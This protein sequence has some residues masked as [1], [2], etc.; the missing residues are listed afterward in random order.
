M[1]DMDPAPEH[2][3]PPPPSQVVGSHAS[4]APPG[5]DLFRI[6]AGG[7]GLTL[8]ADHHGR[9]R[10]VGLGLGGATAEAELDLHWFPEAH[11]VWG[12]ADPLR[13]PALRITH[14]DGTLTTRLRL[15]EVTELAEPEGI[16]HVLT[17][18][19]ELF[20]LTVELHARTHP[21]SGVLEQW[22]EVVHAEDAPVRLC[23]YDSIAPLLLVEADA[24]VVQ[25]GGSGWADEWRWTAQRIHP[26]A[27]SLSTLGVVQPHLQRNPCLLLSP[28]GPSDEHDGEVLGISV[29]WGGNTRIELDLRPAPQP[30]APGTLRLRA[31]A[32]PFAAQYL[33]DPGVRF[34]T[35][36]V[37]WTWSGDG[38]AEVTRRFHDWTRA[39]VLRDPQRLRPLVVN[40]W[41]ATFF[42]FDEDRIKGLIE[43]TADLGADLFLLDDGWF[44]TTRPR[45]DD[46]RGLGDW[47][48]DRRKLPDGLPPLA[49]AAEARR[50]RFG[51]WVE[52]EM[53]N[54]DSELFERHPE[55]VLG[56]R[57]EP[58]LHREQLV[59]D[60]LRP[61]VREFEVGVLDRTLGADPR[62][63]YVKWDANRPL[64][65]AGSP[66]L[67]ADRQENL[68]VDLVRATWEVMDEVVARHPEVEMMLCASGGGRTDHGTLARF[69]EFWTSDNTDPVTRVRMQWAC[70]HFFPTS[71]MAAHVTRWG[72]RPFAFACAVAL[73][74]RFGFDLDL[75]A[76]GPDELAAC[77]AA[78][79]V[80]RRTQPLVQ[81]G[82]LQRYV[83]PVEGDDR[84][85][86][87]LGYTDEE[88]AHAVV[89]AYQLEPAGSPGPSIRPALDPSLEFRVAT[90]D[91]CGP[92]VDLGVRSG[93]ELAES[94]LDWPSD[95]PLTAR[96][97]EIGPAAG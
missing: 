49:D 29:A 69:H 62:I 90:T 7:W 94:G 68:P 34:S 45:D 15:T 19:D 18:T 17:S 6:D 82:R 95:E 80:A 54:P 40:N 4:G 8:G 3:G 38:R 48:P 23:D 52:P 39:R 83:S 51:I 9:L 12:E 56:D 36:K 89:F 5:P 27:C 35:P 11:P 10:Q 44:G 42:E 31:G 71:A 22:V 91:L 25:F 37:V 16:H 92:V 87:A 86:A 75:E 14:H 55:W 21:A 70:S 2:D 66:M 24:E 47:D 72:E 28:S 97:W 76:L 60:A 41:E 74:G 77:R 20:D 96:I 58:R 59:L 78:V 84:S 13:P 61:E 73:S 50:I 53:V 67:A 81:Q 93:A 85:R 30:G 26:G 57:R 33:L 88:A 1:T 46:T 63:S 43:R 65:E 64:T 79:A 32:N